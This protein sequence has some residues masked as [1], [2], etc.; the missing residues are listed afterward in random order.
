M[1]LQEFE[2]TA[3]SIITLFT[4]TVDPRLRE[5][6]TGLWHQK[7]G[8]PEQD[9]NHPARSQLQE[10]ELADEWQPVK[11]THEEGQHLANG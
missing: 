8:K 2:L 4:T 10:H 5:Q 1:S 9:F 11:P 3:Y 7:V 6:D